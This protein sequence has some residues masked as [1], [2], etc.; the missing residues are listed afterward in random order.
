MPRA[1]ASN[2]QRGA[3]ALTRGGRPP[4]SSR[5]PRLAAGSRGSLPRAAGVRTHGS[6]DNGLGLLLGGGRRRTGRQHARKPAACATR[7]P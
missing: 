2:P 7:G 3:A 6:V 4:P 1:P 5:P